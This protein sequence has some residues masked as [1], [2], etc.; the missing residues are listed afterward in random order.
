VTPFDTGALV[1]F[2]QPRQFFAGW[3]AFLAQPVTPR[4]RESS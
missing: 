4:R 2:E 1:Y 3:D